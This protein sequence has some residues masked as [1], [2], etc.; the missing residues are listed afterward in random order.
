MNHKEQYFSQIRERYPT[1]VTQAEFA[2]IAGICKKTA[3]KLNRTGKVTDIWRQALH[4]YLA[5]EA[6]VLKLKD[7]VRIS[8]IGKNSVD[9]W[10]RRRSRKSRWV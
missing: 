5:V 8:G 10:V 6:D 7:V 9:R 2:K 3:Y 1:Y 4:D